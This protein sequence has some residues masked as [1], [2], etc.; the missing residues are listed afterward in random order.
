MLGTQAQTIGTSLFSVSQ[1]YY[2]FNIYKN[3]GSNF[4]KTYN[5]VRNTSK[6]FNYCIILKLKA[7]DKFKEA[8]LEFKMSIK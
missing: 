6:K 3:K 2:I 8:K 7:S 1:W 5:L 4:K